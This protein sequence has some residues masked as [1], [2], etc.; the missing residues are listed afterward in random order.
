MGINDSLSLS[1]QNIGHQLEKVTT[2][3]GWI[4]V[5]LICYFSIKG[6][7]Q[8]IQFMK[9]VSE[10]CLVIK[11]RALLI[12]EAPAEEQPLRPRKPL[13]KQIFKVTDLLLVITCLIICKIVISFLPQI[14]QEGCIA[15][16]TGLRNVIK[17]AVYSLLFDEARLA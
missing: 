7:A 8:L 17:N 5:S 12:N 3:A 1:C 9:E 2:P 6:T 10:R 13:I 16:G 4:V 15:L 11:Q 14:S